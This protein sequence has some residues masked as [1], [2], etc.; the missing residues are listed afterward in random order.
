[1]LLFQ[2]TTQLHDSRAHRGNKQL[3]PWPDWLNAHNTSCILGGSNFEQLACQPICSRHLCKQG[4]PHQ[5]TG[6][7]ALAL[8]FSIMPGRSAHLTLGG[9]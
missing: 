4:W 1:M 2:K 8:A 6:M 3:N 7:H 5:L 9:I